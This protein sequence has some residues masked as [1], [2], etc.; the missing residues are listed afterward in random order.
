MNK[1]P[2]PTKPSHQNRSS[3]SSRSERRPPPPWAD[4]LLRWFVAPHLLE[5]VQG[6][7]QEVFYKR[8]EQVGLA[9]AR[10]EYVWAVLQCLTPFFFL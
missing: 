3:N 7:L 4:R 5:Y 6:D 1:Q 9:R 10:R 8:V 2:D